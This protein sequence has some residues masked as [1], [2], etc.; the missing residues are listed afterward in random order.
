MKIIAFIIIFIPFISCSQ[1]TINV[2]KAIQFGDSLRFDDASYTTVKR[3]LH[4]GLEN[5]ALPAAPLIC[6]SSEAFAFAR[7]V[8]EIFGTLVGGLT[9]N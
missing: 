6:P 5:A 1:T 3:I 9:W 2:K 7:P 8:E 4:E